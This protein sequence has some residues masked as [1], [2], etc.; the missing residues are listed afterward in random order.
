[1]AALG[2]V[3]Q[4]QEMMQQQQQARQE[5]LQMQQ[6]MMQLMSRMAGSTE[7]RAPSPMMGVMPNNLLGQQPFR[8]VGA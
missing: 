4:Q 6:Q 5:Q 3:L 2:F 8:G 7:S 1:M